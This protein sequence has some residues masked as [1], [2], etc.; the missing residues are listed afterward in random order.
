MYDA[1]EMDRKYSGVAREAGKS[2]RPEGVPG[3]PP[4]RAL[5]LGRKTRPGNVPVLQT[6][7]PEVNNRKSHLLGR[8]YMLCLLAVNESESIVQHSAWFLSFF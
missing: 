4:F 5:Q 8:P 2:S 3:P 7:K 6:A 1:W